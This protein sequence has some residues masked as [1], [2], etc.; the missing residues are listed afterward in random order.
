M[1]DK[2][3][4]NAD[5][6]TVFYDVLS[7]AQ[8]AVMDTMLNTE[9]PWFYSDHTDSSGDGRGRFVHL[10]YSQNIPKSNYL[11]IIYPLLDKFYM[12]SLIRV[13]ANLT[14]KKPVGEA[15]GGY[16]VDMN[17]LTCGICGEKECTQHLNL[18]KK[19]VTD[20]F[21]NVVYYLNS[22]NGYTEFEDGK[23]VPSVRNSMVVFSNRLRHR[24]VEHTDGDYQRVV[25]N[26]NFL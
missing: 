7:E 6:A 3:F 10:F 13:K 15:T 24:A 22:N 8:L 25:L 21:T 17:Y 16:H 23:K 14:T 20:Q 18:A 1:M 19:S 2:T 12:H 5:D 26:M 9:F 4:C 11:N